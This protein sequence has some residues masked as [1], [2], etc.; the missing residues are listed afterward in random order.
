MIGSAL[1]HGPRILVIAEDQ[2]F[3]ERCRRGME[4]ADHQ[5]QVAP[6]WWVGAHL[7]G[8]R[9]P[10]LVVVDELL[11]DLDGLSVLAILKAHPS[12]ASLPVVVAASRARDDL[13]TARGPAR[14]GRDRAQ[15]RAHGRTDRGLPQ[16]IE[17]GTGEL[18]EPALAPASTGST[19][20]VT[21]RASSED[22]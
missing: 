21:Q 7:E 12:T 3:G 19:I 2:L 16:T 4:A 8:F 1:V 14:S 18:T 20:P 9:V 5:V 17:E 15:S 13:T 10:D 22:R 11:A 6:G